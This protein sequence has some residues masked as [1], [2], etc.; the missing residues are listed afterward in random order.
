MNPLLKQLLFINFSHYHDVQQS[1]N[2]LLTQLL[3]IDDRAGAL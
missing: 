2:P 1:M 3:F